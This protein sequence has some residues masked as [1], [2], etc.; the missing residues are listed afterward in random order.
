M[1]DHS[2]EMEQKAIFYTRNYYFLGLQ[3]SIVAFIKTNSHVKY[4]EA[5]KNGP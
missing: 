2:Q 4:N 1:V 5:S 3:K